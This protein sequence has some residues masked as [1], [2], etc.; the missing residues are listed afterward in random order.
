MNAWAE[1]LWDHPERAYNGTYRL[2]TADDYLGL[3]F[4][5]AELD[6]GDL[7]LV[8]RHDDGTF[9]EVELEAFAH[10]TSKEIREEQAA[11]FRAMAKDTVKGNLTT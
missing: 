5:A 6:E 4:T 2:A 9:V 11:R 10:V 3:G 1:Q 8:F 7:P